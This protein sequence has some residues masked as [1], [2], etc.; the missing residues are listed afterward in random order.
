MKNVLRFAML[1]V[2]VFFLLALRGFPGDAASQ[3]ETERRY[4]AALQAANIREYDR[5]LSAEPHHLGSAR[6]EQNARWILEKFRE[7]GLDAR[8]E[9]FYVLFPTPKERLLELLSPARFQAALAETPVE[10]DP[11]SSQTSAQLPTYNAYSIDGDVTA[12]LVYVNY[13]VPSDYERLERLGVDVRGKIVIARYGASWRGIKPKVAA[14]KGAIGCLIYSDP[15]D[16]GFFEGEVY[17]KG[18]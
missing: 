12:P 6:G 18:A 13:G 3:R 4:A 9:T 15:R 10:G 8:I 1:L 5:H 11:T 14:E 7:W 17:P 2:P 16:D